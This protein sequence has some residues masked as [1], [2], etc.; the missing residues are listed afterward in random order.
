[1]LVSPSLSVAPTLLVVC[2]SSSLGV[3]PL[4][5]LRM[6]PVVVVGVASPSLVLRPVPLCGASGAVALAPPRSV[7]FAPTLGPSS[8]PPLLAVESLRSLW[9]L[10]P[11]TVRV[12]RPSSSSLATPLTHVATALVA[13]PW[14]SSELRPSFAPIPCGPLSARVL[15]PSSLWVLRPSS[16]V[17]SCVLRSVAPSST[18]APSVVL[19]PYSTTVIYMTLST[20]VLRPSYLVP[21]W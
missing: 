16:L 18:V 4:F 7:V 14:V 8:V 21:S 20:W 17:P 6:G 15:R 3:R 13:T 11:S 9:V 12:L 2:P 19:R 1:L 5:L 10:M